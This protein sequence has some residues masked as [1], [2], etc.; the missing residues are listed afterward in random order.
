MNHAMMSSCAMGR[1]LTGIARGDVVTAIDGRRVQ[2]AAD[3]AAALDECSIGQRVTLSVLRGDDD[4][5]RTYQA[6]LVMSTSLH[7]RC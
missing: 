3:L 5:V 1:T 2:R 7:H 6:I 4:A